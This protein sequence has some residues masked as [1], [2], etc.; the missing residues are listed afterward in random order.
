MIRRSL[1]VHYK[2]F[3]RTR[4]TEDT[5]K[6]LQWSLTLHLM[7][8]A[9][10]TFNLLS[11]MFHSLLDGLVQILLTLTHAGRFLITLTWIKFI[12]LQI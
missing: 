11:E 8:Q 2:H 10:P 5:S 4:S 6:S 3:H 7:A 12:L 9:D 1:A